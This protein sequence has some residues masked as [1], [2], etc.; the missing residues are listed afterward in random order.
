[1]GKIP[2]ADLHCA[3]QYQ[4]WRGCDLQLQDWPAAAAA[5]TTGDLNQVRQHGAVLHKNNTMRWN[6]EHL[7]FKILQL[8]GKIRKKMVRE[9]PRCGSD[10]PTHA[11]RRHVAVGP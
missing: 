3:D 4:G 1:M 10:G 5:R 11:V 8:H 9:Q 7:S 2:E 6:R